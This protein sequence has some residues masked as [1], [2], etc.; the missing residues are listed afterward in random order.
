MLWRW[1]GSGNVAAL[2][3]LRAMAR[4]PETVETFFAELSAATG[5]DRHY[6]ETVRRLHK[7]LGDLDEIELR[8]RRLVERMALALQGSLLLR[9]GH[10]AVADAFCVSRLGGDWGGSFG[11]LPT[12]LDFATIIERAT[13][14][15]A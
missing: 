4:E 1:E 8:A 15:I 2:D 10:P 3:V 6:D 9:Y 7:E 12:G 11:T 5:A 14:K 13:P